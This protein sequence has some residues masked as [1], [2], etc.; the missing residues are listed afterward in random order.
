MKLPWADTNRRPTKRHSEFIANCTARMLS[1]RLSLSAGVSVTGVWRLGHETQ[2]SVTATG[3][4]RM[5]EDFWLAQTPAQLGCFAMSQRRLC[6]SACGDAL[7][8]RLP[9]TS[10]IMRVHRAAAHPPQFLFK[11]QDPK[12]RGD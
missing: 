8:A 5:V 12:S 1:W 4:R 6:A 10:C 2:G 7:G 9:L 11:R 3:A